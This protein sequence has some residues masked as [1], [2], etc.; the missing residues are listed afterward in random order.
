MYCRLLEQN[1]ENIEKESECDDTSSQSLSHP[2][3]A[4]QHNTE[5]MVHHLNDFA[6]HSSKGGVI[7]NAQTKRAQVYPLSA[8]DPS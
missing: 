4:D 5:P 6:V 1:K 2:F 7:T 8:L 3:G